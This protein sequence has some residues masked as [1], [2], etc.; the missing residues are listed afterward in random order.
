MVKS[1]EILSHSEFWMALGSLLQKSA[2]SIGIVILWPYVGA[3]GE[4]R[5]R[6]G[7]RTE[8]GPTE[9][10]LEIWGRSE[11]GAIILWALSRLDRLLPV[12]EA[13]AL[14]L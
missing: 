3:S 12:P 13:P 11:I 10:R 9:Q 8:K 7:E 6:R 14:K 4:T 1:F 5:G 2:S